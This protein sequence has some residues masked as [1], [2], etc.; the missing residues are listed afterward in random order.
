[1]ACLH[2]HRKN[3]YLFWYE[4]FQTVQILGLLSVLVKRSYKSIDSGIAV[5][6]SFM[7]L[8]ITWPISS[9]CFVGFRHRLT[10]NQVKF[11]FSWA[12]FY[13]VVNFASAT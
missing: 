6:Q 11:G 4:L 1:M 13:K 12:N 9:P 5:F 7:D 3:L 8:A 2:V 10:S